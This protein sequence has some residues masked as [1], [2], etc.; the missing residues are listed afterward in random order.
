VPAKPPAQTRRAAPPVPPDAPARSDV[1]PAE[2]YGGPPAPSPRGD[3]RDAV[4]TASG[5]NVVAGIW[6]ILA[7]FVLG[8]RDADPYWNDIVF[9]AVIAALGL[10]RATGAFRES[11]LSYLNALAGAWVFVSAFWLDDSGQAIWNDLI[12]GVIV[13]V[14]SLL[15]A[16]ASDEAAPAQARRF[17]R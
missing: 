11:W 17:R 16:S 6:L 2:G 9:G 8:Y 13:V 4:A 1:P 15:S 5:L 14:L 7:P 3:W 10:I 12:V